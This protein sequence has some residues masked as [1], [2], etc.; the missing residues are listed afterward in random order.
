[1]N[2][3]KKFIAGLND[4]QKKLLVIAIVIVIAAVF[5]RI[6]IGPTMSHL[7]SVEEDIIKEESTI[8][9]DVRFL[10]YKDRILQER[11]EIDPY[12]TKSV[13]SD[14]E[15]TEAFIKKIENLA[16][17]TNVSLIK[18]NPAPSEQDADYW[19]Y[20]TDLECSGNL[21]DIIAFMHLVNSDTDLMKV[22]KYN[23]SGK[24]SDTDEIKATMTIEKIV[25][26]DSSMPKKAQDANT[27]PANPP[28]T[29]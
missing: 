27:S 1:M 21:A 26:P 20:Q 12:L 3:I 16:N 28:A 22:D 19:K 9:Q 23:F 8:K 14:V 29:P 10:G 11:K 13:S 18:N 7:A 5:D 4:S 17:Q 24:K 2:E 25:V 6:L 15:M